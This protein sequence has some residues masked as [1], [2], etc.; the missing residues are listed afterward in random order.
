MKIL[1]SIIVFSFL[2][3]FVKAQSEAV[4]DDFDPKKEVVFDGKRF[5]VWNS[6]LTFGGLSGGS[7]NKVVPGCQ[8][9][10]AIDLNIHIKKNYFQSGICLSGQTFGNY[11]DTEFHL[12][13][14][15]RI[16]KKHYNFAAFGGI[17]YS[18]FYVWNKD[19][20]P[21]KF[22][23]TPKTAPGAY[24]AV[25]NFFKFKYD[26]GIGITLYAS[27]NY[28]RYLFGMRLEMFFSNAYRGKKRILFNT[29]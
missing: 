13:W 7:I 20:I 27:Y 21:Q 9:A 14:G 6:Y 4:K 23:T 29:D 26:V 16:E 1:F 8:F 17:D 28:S 12:C 22:N 10:G 11:S 24:L 3:S 19:S 5:R 15:K 18:L 25:Q 2:I